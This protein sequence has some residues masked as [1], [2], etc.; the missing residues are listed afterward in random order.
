MK[1]SKL[2]L[3]S[4][5]VFTL[6]LSAC[7]QSVNVTPPTPL[8][9]QTV[10]PV[11]EIPPTPTLQTV[12]LD[13]P[14]IGSTISWFDTS[15][16]IHVPEG[17]FV[18]GADEPKGQDFN[19]AH[20]VA[21]DGFWIYSTKVTNEMYNLC[22]S[23]GQCTPPA[24]DSTEPASTLSGSSIFVSVSDPNDPAI[25]DFPVTNV[26]WDQAN[27]Y[28]QWVGGRLPTEAEWE[29]TAR[30]SA[31]QI[32][33]WGDASP[34]CDL[35]NFGEC[36]G[37]LSGVL[38]HPDG[39]SE[40]K[41]LDMAG[42]AY[43][44]VSDWYQADYYTQSP[45]ANPTG[46][47]TGTMRSIR[48]SSFETNSESL[49]TFQRTALSPRQSRIDLGFR[50]VIDDPTIFAPMCSDP[51]QIIVNTS[52]APQA[53]QSV[54][55]GSNNSNS[56][57][58]FDVNNILPRNIS[59]F[60]VD[61]KNK[62]GGATLEVD[63]SQFLPFV[64]SNC[65]SY[66]YIDYL[67]AGVLV[68]NLATANGYKAQNHYTGLAGTTYPMFRALKCWPKQPSLSPSP[69]VSPSCA[70]GYIMQSNGSCLFSWSSSQ[71][72]NLAC[73][74]GYSFNQQA[75]CC[76]V[77]PASVGNTPSQYPA[78]GPGSLFDPQKKACYKVSNTTLLAAFSMDKFNLYLGACQDKK[79][80]D[81][82]KPQ[83]PQQPPPPT[84]CTIDPAT[85]ACN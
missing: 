1:Q 44:W 68:S 37:F 48:G 59:S 40:Y 3:Y 26:T 11:T 38:D 55:G 32:Y 83:Q 5:I 21:L 43:E 31:S 2:F 8:P 36:G 18:M 63:W 6:I 33:P 57:I 70:P 50:C 74:M 24:S 49:Q 82:D 29:K 76:T 69:G 23:V 28:C 54:S 15:T 56:T 72:G 85:G 13:A 34:S 35:L 41:A 39:M 7:K 17:E 16:L 62:L 47:E 9:A 53:G 22:V 14:T 30:G 19:P 60:C 20:L 65:S 80:A 77:N 42:N 10:A 46:P 25:K 71:V 84:P 4:L 67:S 51:A 79:P 66:Y 61:L 27:T 12:V 73:P 45:P 78:C 81:A 52:A 58:N 64:Q 75:Q